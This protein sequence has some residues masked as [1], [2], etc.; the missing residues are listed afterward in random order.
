[1]IDQA[2]P[3]SGR[4]AVTVATVPWDRVRAFADGRASIAGCDATF[5]PVHPEDAFRRAYSTQDYDIT[6]ISA[7]SHILTTARGTSPYIALPIPILRVFRHGYIYVRTDRIR[8]PS[9]LRGKRV[10]VPE[11]QMTAALWVRGLL[12]DEYC[13]PPDQLLWRTGGL[14]QAGARAERTPLH[15]PASFDVQPIPTDRTLSEMLE[16]GDLD[17]VVAPEI[18]SCLRRGAPNVGRLFA[19]VRAAEEQYHAKTGLFPIMHFIAIRRSLL[20]AQPWLAMEVFKAF[21]QARQFAIEDSQSLGAHYPIQLPWY[22]DDIERTRRAMGSDFW[23]YGVTKNLR[24]I[25]AMRRWSIEQGLSTRE[26][27]TNELF[28]AETLAT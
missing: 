24:E 27:R 7:S 3:K 19:D 1:M 16:S 20:D 13:L 6:E 11:Y 21:E 25:E 12:S 14:E 26:P 8:E 4:L 10:G 15:L 18:P 5:I 28:A 22:S 2:V 9:D 17:A 23:P